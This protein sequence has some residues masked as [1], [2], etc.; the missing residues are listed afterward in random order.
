MVRVLIILLL[1]S[2]CNTAATVRRTCNTIITTCAVTAMTAKVQPRS[3]A[4]VAL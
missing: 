3:T 4:E 1:Q 2:Y